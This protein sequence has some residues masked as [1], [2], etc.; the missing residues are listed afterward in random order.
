MAVD[1]VQLRVEVFNRTRFHMVENMLERPTDDEIDCALFDALDDINSAAPTTN[2]TIDKICEMTDKRWKRMLIFGGAKNTVG[3]LVADWTANGFD[4]Q[5]EEFNVPSKL[6]DYSSLWTEL[7]NQFNDML[8]KLKK[9]TQ[10][11][12]KMATYSTSPESD[13]RY[14]SQRR[15]FNYQIMYR[16]G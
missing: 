12:A 3:M 9:S 16:V 13:L 6:S 15:Y 8:D 5:I 11:F 14:S 1:M 4:A 7:T 10:K 2:F